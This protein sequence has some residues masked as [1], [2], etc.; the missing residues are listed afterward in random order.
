[1]MDHLQ[2]GK[3]ICINGPSF[4]GKTY[5]IHRLIDYLRINFPS[6][7]ISS[8]SFELSYKKNQTYS[9]M[10][11]NYREILNNKLLY[12]DI[13][14]SESTVINYD[15]SLNILVYLN[16]EL[17]RSNFINYIKIFGGE[18]AIKRN[19]Y[20]NVR[21]ALDEFDNIYDCKPSYIVR[22]NDYTNAFKVIGDYVR[23]K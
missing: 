4:T 9:H 7:S 19:R 6:K 5:F 14:I 22:E 1:M 12:Y 21:K 3:L 18:D 20:F 13:V 17:I 15:D 10:L 23:D 16:E 8:N 11:K 2:R